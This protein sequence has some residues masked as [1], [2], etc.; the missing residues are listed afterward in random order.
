M[1]FA[2]SNTKTLFIVEILFHSASSVRMYQC[3]VEFVI[4]SSH[5]HL[6]PSAKKL[7]CLGLAYI[8]A[9]YQ[10]DLPI[11][12]YIPLPTNNPQAMTHS[13]A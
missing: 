5:V 6:P 3:E 7:V 11:P 12:S 2:I 4:T 13:L 1:F 10:T 9:L 8:S